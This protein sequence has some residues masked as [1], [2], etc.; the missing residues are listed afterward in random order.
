MC[1]WWLFIF[2]C[3][4]ATLLGTS[5]VIPGNITISRTKNDS[6]LTGPVVFGVNQNVSIWCL[7]ENINGSQMLQGLFWRDYN[8]SRVYSMGHTNN[9]NP[10]VYSERIAGNVGNFTPTWIRALHFSR[11]QPSYAGTYKC[12]A[13]YNKLYMNETVEVQIA[14][15][16][17]LVDMLTS[18]THLICFAPY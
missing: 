10:D 1:E 2:P 13:N 9:S 14:G 17:R 3:I 4:V 18:S 7:A 12:T 11:V 15:W 5:E 6:A 8:G 16:C